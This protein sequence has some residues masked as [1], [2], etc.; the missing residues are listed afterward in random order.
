MRIFTA[1]LTG[2]DPGAD[3]EADWLGDDPRSRFTAAADAD[4]SAWGSPDALV[5]TVT[6]SMGSLPGP[7]AGVV[8]LTEICRAR[9]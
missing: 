1:R 8:H 2:K 3:H 7:M 5:R 4:R 9:R 6:I